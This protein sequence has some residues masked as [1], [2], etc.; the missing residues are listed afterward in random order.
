LTPTPS[1]SKTPQNEETF[2]PWATNFT[3]K[4]VSDEAQKKFREWAMLQTPKSSLHKFVSQDNLPPNRGRNFKL[5]DD[6]DLKLFGQFFKQQTTTVLGSNEKW[7]V[8]Q[9]NANGGRYTV[10][11]T[12]SGNVG[13]DY[14]LDQGSSQ[15]FVITS[16]MNFQAS[17]PG[18]D[19]SALLA[20][21]FF[22]VVQRALFESTVGIPTKN[23]AKSSENSFPVWFV[24]GTANF[25]G[26]SIAALA[27][28]TTYWEG[29]PM[30]FSYAPR[31]PSVNRNTLEDYEIRNGPGNDSPTYPYIAGQAATEYLVASLGFQKMLDIWIDFKNTK[32][33][34]ISF[35]KV[36]GISKNA[37]YEKFEKVRTNLGLP[38][39][40]WKLVCLTNTPIK[41]LP[42]TTEP[43]N[44]NVNSSPNPGFT[45]PPVDKT[46]D[47][48]GQGCSAGEADIKNSFGTFVCTGMANG[49]NLWKKKT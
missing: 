8:D 20:H 19:G 10:C 42:K 6:L 32:S 21:E 18:S 41:D 3:Q 44:Y 17:N 7:V 47:I 29:R 26:F 4:Q 13:L 30:M 46:A 12:N 23:G 22:H 27:L 5:V 31:T 39:V 37:F 43:C 38:E 28:N 45:P 15:G 36:T 1:E 9:L 16:D 25:V 2:T 34:E 24:E 33:F 40:S 48:D 49:N 11:N 35:E 14:C